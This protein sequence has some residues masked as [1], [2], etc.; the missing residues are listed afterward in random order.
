MD[1]LSIPPI[2]Y[3]SYCSVTGS[4]ASG[5]GLRRWRWTHRV[6]HASVTLVLF[7]SLQRRQFGPLG[8]YLHDPGYERVH[9]DGLTIVL[10]R[11]QR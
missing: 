4:E 2:V 11:R 9:A 7:T 5:G 3:G 8:P 1:Y 6:R 10:T